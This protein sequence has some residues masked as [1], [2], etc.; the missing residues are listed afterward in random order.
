MAGLSLRERASHVF[1]ARF[2]LFPARLFFSRPSKLSSDPQAY[3]TSPGSQLWSISFHVFLTSVNQDCH[4]P[5]TVFFPHFFRRPVFSGSST[6][7]RPPFSFHGVPS[8]SSTLIRLQL[9]APA[10]SIHTI[11]YLLDMAT[12]TTR[13][14]SYRN[15]SKSTDANS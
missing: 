15:T 8:I 9:S 7:L 10:A 3:P 1:N 6:P 12:V 13:P 5:V 11:V 4:W 2:S 14:P